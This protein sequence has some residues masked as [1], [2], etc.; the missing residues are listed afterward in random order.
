MCE[1]QGC[2]DKQ[3]GEEG[4]VLVMS[5]G[6]RVWRCGSDRVGGVES[7]RQLCVVVR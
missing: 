6:S 4:G 7:G 3:S 5:H 2:H 1:K